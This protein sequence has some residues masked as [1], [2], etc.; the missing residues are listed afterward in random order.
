M[1]MDD[2]DDVCT[3]VKISSEILNLIVIIIMII[4]EPI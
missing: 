1:M 2:D 3:Y 4:T